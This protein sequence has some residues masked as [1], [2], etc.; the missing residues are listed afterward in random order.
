MKLSEKKILRKKEQI[1]L[2]AIEIVNRRGYSGATMEEIA[3]ELLMTKGSLYYYFK[4]KSDLMYQCHNFVLS[5][6][7][8][9]LRDILNRGEGSATEI[10]VKMIAT[11]MEYAIEEKEVFNLIME[12]KR[13]FNEEQLELVLKLRKEYENLFDQ[14][15][16]RGITSGEFRVEEPFIERMII[17]GAMNWVQ[18][19]Y[20]P[21][22]RL[23]KEEV[24]EKYT[25]SILKILK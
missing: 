11:H 14:I 24:I 19:W 12:P 5:Q 23:V 16:K 25:K 1:L 18:Q 10:L 20:N 7:T 13:F 15:I 17:L 6:G 2:S 8:E 3:A 9:D 4:N 22:G 21:D